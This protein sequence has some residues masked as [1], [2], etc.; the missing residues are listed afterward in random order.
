MDYKMKKNLMIGFAFI[1]LIAGICFASA[2]VGVQTP[3][4][5][6]EKT[7]SG[8]YCQD[9]PA[10]QCDPSSRQVPTSCMATS[11]CRAGTCFD[12]NEGTC[13][14]STPQLVCNM[15]HGIWSA[16]LP[17]Q[18]TLGC[19]VLGDQAAFVTLT[20][21]K[22]LSS[23]FGLGIN[24]KKDI[25][26]EAACIASVTGQEKG[27]CV[28]ESEFQR[29]CRLTTREDCMGKPGS[30]ANKT[31]GTEFYA[32][33]LCSDENLSTICTSTTRTTCLPGKEEVYFV[34]SCGNPANIYDASKY[35]D[36]D[37]WANIKTKDESCGSASA[38][39]NSANCGNCN[40]LLGSF[41]RATTRGTAQ[42][43]YGSNICADLNCRDTQN[44]NDYKHGESWC[45]YNDEGEY[46]TSDN[47]VGSGFF[48]H[49]CINGEEVLEACADY[50]SHVCIEQS[51][52]FTGGTF[53]QAACRVNRWQDC[54]GQTAKDDCENED[55]RDCKW[56]GGVGDTSYTGG[57][58][59]VQCVPL[60]SPGLNFWGGSEAKAICGAASAKCKVKMEQGLFGS[61]GVGGTDWK[62]TDGEHCAKITSGDD[63][64]VKDTWKDTMN[65]RCNAMGDCGVKTNWIG[66]DGELTLNE[67]FHTSGPKF[68]E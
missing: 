24:Y 23:D 13:V 61:L 29:T 39:P 19:C 32:G 36:K 37:Y 30:A 21:C 3:T 27:A 25:K 65:A 14:E 12:S 56:V 51:I 58:G 50:R 67:M 40:Y 46:D 34:D 48:K 4:V 55:K 26:N 49:I 28:F 60:N 18:C 16:A 57:N 10:E 33:K 64:S 35:N 11:Y 54:I 38:N 59:S 1:F 2:G 8:L 52:Q 53:S 5:C 43:T 44:G 41:C 6:C 7:I 42:A 20:R 66:E 9:V 45:V 47:T 63:I 62:I 31:K 68:V 17:V 15:N 22:K